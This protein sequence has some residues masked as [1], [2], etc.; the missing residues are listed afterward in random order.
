[1]LIGVYKS[2]SKWYVYKE[3][4][5]NPFHATSLFLYP[6]KSSENYRVFSGSIEKNN[7]GM[8]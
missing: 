2:F 6:L 1:M 3:R 5:F 4:L 7:S 8:K